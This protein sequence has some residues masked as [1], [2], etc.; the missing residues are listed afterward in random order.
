MT[1]LL[2]PQDF[3]KTLIAKTHLCKSPGGYNHW[4]GLLDW[5][6]GLDYWTGLLDWT[7]GLL[8]WTT[9]LTQTVK[10]NSFSAEQKLKL[11]YFLSYFANTAPY[12][13][14]PGISRGQRSHTYLISFILGG[15]A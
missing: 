1:S 4:T 12:S 15:C 6:T 2:A 10:C 13:V 5:T 3:V 9:G 7:T 8:D 14:F 11:S